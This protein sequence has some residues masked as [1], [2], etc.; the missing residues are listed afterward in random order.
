M[1]KAWLVR[2]TA[3]KPAG[4]SWRRSLEIRL[5]GQVERG[6]RGAS[7]ASA[8]SE[9]YSRWDGIPLGVCCGVNAG[10]RLEAGVKSGRERRE[11]WTGVVGGSRGQGGLDLKYHL[12]INQT[13]IS[14]LDT[15]V[16]KG[17]P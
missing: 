12:E 9:F 6:S 7:G 1:G 10:T 2:G 5:E 16:N 13:G 8:E 4:W 14:D 3:R 11:V 15:G 17:R